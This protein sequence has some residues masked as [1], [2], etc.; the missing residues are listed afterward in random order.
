MTFGNQLTKARKENDLTQEQLAEKLNL[1]RQTILRW[2]KNQVFPDIS[3]L[4]AVTEVLEVSFNYLLGETESVEE[5]TESTNILTSLIDQ[6]VKIIFY[7]GH[8]ELYGKTL[9]VLDV[10]ED[11]LQIQYTVNDELV[12][13]ILSV[14]AIQSFTLVT[15]GGN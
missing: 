5:K 12:M 10:E 8:L 11:M 14:S 4:R 7:E 2:E 3:N 6:Q 13:K 1:S 9:F 15:E